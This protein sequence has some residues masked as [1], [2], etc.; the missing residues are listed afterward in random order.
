MLGNGE[1]APLEPSSKILTT[2]RSD[3]S[4]FAELLLLAVIPERYA[5]RCLTLP[6]IGP[7]QNHVGGPRGGYS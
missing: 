7:F 5:G 3:M 4:S 6:G 2:F 1:L